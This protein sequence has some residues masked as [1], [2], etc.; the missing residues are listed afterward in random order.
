MLANR[1]GITGVTQ[2]ED[3]DQAD[4]PTAAAFVREPGDSDRHD[5][6]VV[7]P[8]EPGMEARV[9]S[10]PD[11]ASS[12]RADGDHVG[13]GC[14]LGL[15]LH[16][17]FDDPMLELGRGIGEDDDRAPDLGDRGFVRQ[18]CGGVCWQ[19]QRHGFGS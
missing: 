6:R 2:L 1:I 8:V 3:V 13:D 16:P 9:G 19:S 11:V 5:P 17:C 15:P 18:L 7:T 10:L 14:R 4:R 12:R